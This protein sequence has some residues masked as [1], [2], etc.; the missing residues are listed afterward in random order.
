MLLTSSSNSKI[1]V[2]CIMAFGVN[3]C[4]SLSSSRKAIVCCSVWLQPPLVLLPFHARWSCFYRWFCTKL[5][6]WDQYPFQTGHPPG[7]S[8]QVKLPYNFWVI[9][10]C[11]FL[12]LH[13]LLTLLQQKRRFEHYRFKSCI[14]FIV[15]QFRAVLKLRQIHSSFRIEQ[16]VYGLLSLNC[17]IKATDMP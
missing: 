17:L 15:M 2:P 5:H 12:F 3:I 10:L 16:F 4:M 14:V 9:V 8:A 6:L 11:M 1:P 7:C 13:F